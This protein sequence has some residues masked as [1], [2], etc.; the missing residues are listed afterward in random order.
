MGEFRVRAPPDREIRDGRCSIIGGGDPISG[1]V[2]ICPSLFRSPITLAGK[3]GA[4]ILAEEIGRGH[5]RLGGLACGVS[6]CVGSQ[7]GY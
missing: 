6:G 1:V 5:R 7:E 3:T 4:A 2:E